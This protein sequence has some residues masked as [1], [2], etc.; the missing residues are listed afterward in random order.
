MEAMGGIAITD[1][2]KV[3]SKLK[4]ALVGMAFQLRARFMSRMRDM[5]SEVS[6]VNQ[7]TCFSL[8]A[9]SLSEVEER[10]RNLINLCNRYREEISQQLLDEDLKMV[11]VDI[12]ANELPLLI[13]LNSTY[14]TNLMRCL[15]DNGIETCRYH[16]PSI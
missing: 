5:N 8:A 11:E 12:Q 14:S 16:P 1:D 10:K 7:V 13:D 3:A 4:I 2:E 15:H 6:I 9:V